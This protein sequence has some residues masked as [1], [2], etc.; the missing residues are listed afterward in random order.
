MS[1]IHAV[2]MLTPDTNTVG[3]QGAE[4]TSKVIG[5]PLGQSRHSLL[6]EARFFAGLPRKHY[7]PVPLSPVF[8]FFIVSSRLTRCFLTGWAS[9]E[10]VVVS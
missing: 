5:F 4:G 9:L 3:F 2:C 6:Q 8:L 10:L 1:A 7:K